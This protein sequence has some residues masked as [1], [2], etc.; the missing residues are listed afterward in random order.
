MS[1]AEIEKTVIEL[2][3]DERRRFAAWFYKNEERILPAAPDDHDVAGDISP[4]LMEELVRRRKE[5]DSGTVRLISPEEMFRGMK[6]AVD[7]V[8]RSRH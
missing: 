1:L 6:E 5:L 2:P 3:E 4:E 8:R 7:E